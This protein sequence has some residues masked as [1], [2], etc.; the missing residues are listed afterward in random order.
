MPP[1]PP[2]AAARP[3]AAVR[4]AAAVRPAAAR[5]AAALASFTL[6]LAAPAAAQ[7]EPRPRE[8]RRPDVI[9]P[10]MPV[11]G[12]DS[13]EDVIAA[14]RGL[15]RGGRMMVERLPL[16]AGGVRV[17]IGLER[18][19]VF[20]PDA[21]I[22]VHRAA[23]EERISPPPDAWLRGSVVGES[24][25]LAFLAVPERGAPRGLVSR[26]GR[27]FLIRGDG[28]EAALGRGRLLAP[29]VEAP[30]EQAFDC[31][32]D[33][34]S[35]PELAGVPP[36]RPIPVDP[37]PLPGGDLAADVPGGLETVFAAQE[38][39]PAVTVSHTARVA[40]ETDHELFLRLGS[41][42]AATA[43]VG[44]LFA[45]LSGLYAREIG[46]TLEVVHLSLWDSPSDPWTQ[47]S[48]SCGMYEFGRFWNRNRTSI[49]R[50]I[51]H[52]LSGKSP[53]AGIAWLGVLCRGGFIVDHGGSCP[54]LS[55]QRD[56][57]GGAY[58]FTGGIGG[59]FD[60]ASPALVWD[61]LGVAHEIGHNFDSPHTHCYGGLGGSS[62]PVDQ[63]SASECGRAGCF[64]GTPSLP[65]GTAG[66]GCGTLMSYCHLLSGGLRNIS[67]TF[68]EGHP[69]GVL[70]GRVPQRM[71]T[72][73][74]NQALGDP[75]CLALIGGGG[76]CEDDVVSSVTISS[77][78]SFAA[79][80]TLFVGPSVRVTATGHATFTARRVA[81]GDGFSVA[82][83]GRLTVRTQ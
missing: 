39:L 43:Y 67:F 76:P 31:R 11:A 14:A 83:G 79:C 66:A 20:A 19:D 54:T 23:G 59:S 50:T 41:R 52:F 51:A 10:S 16:G 65:C 6:L 49:D 24:D 15:S 22:V 74:A 21:E 5:L 57:Y 1:S 30:A 61:V 46:T 27:V 13:I 26:R 80:D 29:E 77:A 55:P 70:P 4:L 2:A 34:V 73:V 48:P 47:T 53:T 45:Y 64:C 81:I 25:T 9:P 8:P 78:Q 56:D 82:S 36:A 33:E 75:A 7:P 12:A 35:I 32:L 28:P 58:G 42:A 60:P 69:F 63:C 37:A 18:I 3:A 62:Q 17:A 68:G 44:D 72:H 38:A 71:R 40:V